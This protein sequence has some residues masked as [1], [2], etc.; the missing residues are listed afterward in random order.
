[1]IP[2]NG[3]TTTLD[4]LWMGVPVVALKGDRGTSRSTYSILQS[5]SMPE[6]IAGSPADYVDLNV[7]IARGLEWRQALRAT[8]RDR[9]TASPLMDAGTFVRDLEVHYR[10]IWR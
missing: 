5:L 7:R 8:L 6:L 9:L 2:H 10:A 1:T 3:A 4:A